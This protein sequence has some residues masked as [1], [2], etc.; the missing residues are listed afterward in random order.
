MRD[1][2]LHAMQRALDAQGVEG[3]VRAWLDLRFADVADFMRNV[4]G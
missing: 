2:W 1:A 4:E 3:P